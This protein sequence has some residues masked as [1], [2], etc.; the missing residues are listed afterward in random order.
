[1]ANRLTRNSAILAK[2]ETTAGVDAAPTGAANAML[3]S[4]Q[5]VTPLSASNVDRALVRPYLGGSEQLLGPAH[6]EVQFDVELVGSGTAGVAPAWGPLLRACGFAETVTASTRVDYT[7]ISTGFETVTIYYFDDGVLHKL[8]GARGEWSARLNVGG[9]PV[10]SFKFIG[11][12][13]GD[14][15]LGAGSTTLSG[16]KTPQVVSNANSQSIK[17][18]CT[19]S[20]TGAPAL[21]AGT[22]Y[23]SQGLELASG[24]Q[25]NF[26]PLVGVETV[27]MT[28]RDIT[29]KV[30]LDLTA[31]DE[32][33][34]MAD[35][36]AATLRSMG[37]V[38]GTVAGNRVLVFSPSVQLTN[39]TKGEVN[40][41]RMVGYD[42]RVVPDPAGSGNDELRIVTSF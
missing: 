31:A 19:H 17:F 34:F 24:N 39:P 6:K 7:L 41:K 13:G 10:L 15:V 25:V 36:K 5:S 27:D 16:F 20:N 37:M 8:L 21:T 26:T 14:V 38:H 12:D 33:S 35:V 32:V 40:G 1:M 28:G 29:A 4:N 30:M 11:L 3:V 18:G 23:T 22:P 2:I 42:L 9:K